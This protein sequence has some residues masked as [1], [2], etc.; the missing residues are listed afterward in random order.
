MATPAL[1]ANGIEPSSSGTATT[2]GQPHLATQDLATLVS[3]SP[4]VRSVVMCRAVAWRRDD[5]ERTVSTGIMILVFRLYRTWLNLLH[6][7][8]K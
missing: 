5:C 2:Q 1:V 3:K 4:V 7:P 8:Q 6:S